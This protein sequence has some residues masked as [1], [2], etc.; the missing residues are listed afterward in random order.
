MKIFM[1][2]VLSVLLCGV[3][4]G[5]YPIQGYNVNPGPIDANELAPIQRVVPQVTRTI[6][7]GQRQPDIFHYHYHEFGA[8]PATHR[9]DGF[10]VNPYG[11]YQRDLQPNYCQQPQYYAPQNYCQP[12][13]PQYQPQPFYMFVPQ[14]YQQPYRYGSGPRV[15]ILGFQQ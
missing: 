7:L 14:Q 10:N 15:N 4:Y 8:Q 2:V 1:S 6:P 3:C 5:Q 9:S 12:Q 11:C 13:I